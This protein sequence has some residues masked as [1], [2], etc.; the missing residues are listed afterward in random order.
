MILNPKL[1]V[2]HVG[3]ACEDMDK[4]ANFIRN[5]MNVVSETERV[6]DPLQDAT[7]CILKLEDGTR[8]ELIT[9]NMVKDI[10][11]KGVTYYHL[12]YT[13]P[14]INKTIDELKEKFRAI[15]ISSPKPAKIFDGRLAAFLYTPLG[16]LELLEV[17]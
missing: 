2:H 13:T 16:V 9:G 10:I 17:S 5:T 4:C 6:F 7:V 11:A 8:L 3:I 1:E 15:V 14:D 12:C